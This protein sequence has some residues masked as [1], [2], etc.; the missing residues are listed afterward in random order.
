MSAVIVGIIIYTYGFPKNLN[1]VKHLES[2]I[3]LKFIE[4]IV[5]KNNHRSLS[6][7]LNNNNTSHNFRAFQESEVFNKPNQDS[8][9]YVIDVKLELYN[10]AEIGDRI[11]KLPNSNK[12]YLHKTDSIFRFNLY[13]ITEPERKHLKNVDEWSNL[14]IGYVPKK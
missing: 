2:R 14:E 11:E 7:Y 4:F 12:C 8:V 9:D 6:L 3:N 5:Y 1:A 10:L 13:D